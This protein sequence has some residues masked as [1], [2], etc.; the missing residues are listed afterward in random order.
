[1][2][3]DICSRRPKKSASSSRFVLWA[4]KSQRADFLA[5]CTSASVLPAGK[6]HVSCLP[7]AAHYTP[8]ESSEG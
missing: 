7:E 6:V 4:S 2:T 3:G 5:N 1:M 8:K